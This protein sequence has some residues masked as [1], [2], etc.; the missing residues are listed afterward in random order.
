MVDHSY[1]DNAAC[2]SAGLGGRGQG[3]GEALHDWDY[4]VDRSLDWYVDAEDHGRG[5]QIALSPA[6]VQQLKEGDTITVHL[7]YTQGSAAH[8]M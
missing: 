2:G 5:S 7:S 1:P 4:H 8:G 3:A 6:T